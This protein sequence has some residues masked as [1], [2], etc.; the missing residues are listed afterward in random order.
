MKIGL[1]DK[2]GV[3]KMGTTKSGRNINTKG[4]G[5]SASDFAVVHSNEGS[6][7]WTTGKNNHIR[8]DSGGHGQTGLNELQKYGIK[9]NI[10]NILYFPPFSYK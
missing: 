5:R 2:G 9:Y 7:R 8:L 10:V 4:S 6:Y 3:T 1:Q